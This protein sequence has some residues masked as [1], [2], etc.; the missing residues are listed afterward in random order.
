[1]TVAQNI[2]FGLHVQKVPKEERRAR[3]TELLHLVGLAGLEQRRPAQL[4]GGQRQRV[5]LARALAPRPRLLLLDEPFAAVDAKVREELRD[6]LRRLHDEVQLTSLFVTHDQDEAFALADRVVI[7]GGGRVEQS[8]TPLEIMDR[9]CSEFVARFI[10]EANVYEASVTGSTARVGSVA[11]TLQS[12]PGSGRARVVVRSY[13]LKLWADDAGP[14]HVTRV[15]SLGDRVKVEG[16]I[17]GVYPVVAYFPRRSSLLRGLVPGGRAGIEVTLARAYPCA[18]EPRPKG[19]FDDRE[20][21]SAASLT[22]L[23]AAMAM[24]AARMRL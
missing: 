13:D 16:S 3:V 5:A 8:G 17:D 19:A 10:G 21:G 18:D 6:W 20:W 7:V 1:M 22:R 24:I 2:E 4:S 9:P 11:M 15:V 12:A 14:V 23:P